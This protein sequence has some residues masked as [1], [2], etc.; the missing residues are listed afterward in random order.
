VI[1]VA[2]AHDQQLIPCYAAS[3]FV[4]FLV[5]LLAMARL[6]RRKWR[7]RSAVINPIAAIAA[8][9]SSS[10]DFAVPFGKPAAGHP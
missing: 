4:S 1:T 2:G 3:V 7:H 10:S 9:F 6:A 5:G 8:A